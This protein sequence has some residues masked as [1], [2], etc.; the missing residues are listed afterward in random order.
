MVSAI[1][2]NMVTY[3]FSH[4]LDF[5]IFSASMYKLYEPAI[6][7]ILAQMLGYNAIE[8]IKN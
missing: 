5:L 2:A 8:D 1:H 6:V 4:E 3:M 7:R